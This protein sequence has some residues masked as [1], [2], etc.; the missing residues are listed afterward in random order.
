M[1]C[2]KQSLLPIKGE[3]EWR[4]TYLVYVFFYRESC[5]ASWT[6]HQGL[7]LSRITEVGR[8]LRISPCSVRVSSH[9]GPGYSKLWREPSLL[10]TGQRITNKGKRLTANVS[11]TGILTDSRCWNS[12]YIEVQATGSDK[13]LPLPP[14]FQLATM[15]IRG[16]QEKGSWGPPLKKRKL[17]SYQINQQQMKMTTASSKMKVYHI[18]F[19]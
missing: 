19:Q 3:G 13:H 12:F 6:Q 15:R 9:I 14:P 8:D 7:Y 5:T 1:H 11:K 18:A 16:K 10:N 17:K 4:H 2:D